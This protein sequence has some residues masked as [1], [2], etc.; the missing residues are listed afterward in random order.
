MKDLKKIIGNKKKICRYCFTTENLTIDHKKSLKN[1]GEST[2]KN[3]QY[4]CK[5]CNSFKADINDRRFRGL[6]KY[7]EGV[8]TRR[9]EHKAKMKEKH[10]A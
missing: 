2:H 1:G 10:N 8:V 5:T 4:L 7:M 6:M 3:L 9:L